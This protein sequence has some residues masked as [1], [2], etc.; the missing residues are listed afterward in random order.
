MRIWSLHPQYLDAKGL[1]AL[2]RETLLA[3]KV[4]LGLTKGYRQ[5][6]QLK[7][8]KDL[9]HPVLAVNQYLEGVYAEAVRRGYHFDKAKFDVSDVPTLMTVTTGQI[10]YERQHLLKKLAV[11]DKVRY[12]AFL[13]EENILAHPIFQLREGEVEK[14]E[15]L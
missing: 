5:H 2:W 7:R 9:T 11:R 1:V 15:V 14:W 10:E 13:M 8:F 12:E 6:S 4:L 3:K